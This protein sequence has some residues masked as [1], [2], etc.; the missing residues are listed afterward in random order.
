MTTLL[1]K[2]DRAVFSVDESSYD[3][4]VPLTA[5]A[6]KYGETNDAWFMEGKSG[7]TPIGSP[8]INSAREYEVLQNI[9]EY[10]KGD[11]RGSNYT[12]QDFTDLLV[13]EKPD[14]KPSNFPKD[15]VGRMPIFKNWESHRKYPQGLHIGRGIKGSGV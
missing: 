15:D 14:A 5:N 13:A 12:S 2:L 10:Q 8:I 6:R 9:N 1:E 7:L 11:S 3:K 4:T